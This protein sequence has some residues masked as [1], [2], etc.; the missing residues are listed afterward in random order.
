[1]SPTSMSGCSIA[2]KWPL[3]PNSVQ[4]TMLFDCS[5]KRRIEVH[6]PQLRRLPPGQNVVPY[7][8]SQTRWAFDVYDIA[9]QA[10][11]SNYIEVEDGRGEYTYFPVPVCVG[12]RA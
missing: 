1:M 5:A 12:G 10:M 2:A 4:C 3:W 11:S 7:H 9:T 8:V 6:V